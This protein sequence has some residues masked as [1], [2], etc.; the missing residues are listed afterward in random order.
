VVWR[1]SQ[2]HSPMGPDQEIEGGRVTRLQSC[3]GFRV[4]EFESYREAGWAPLS[5][6]TL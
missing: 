5:P 1:L 2:V 3:K 4:A 6:E